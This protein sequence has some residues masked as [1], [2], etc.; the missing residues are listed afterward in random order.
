MFILNFI[1]LLGTKKLLLNF[2]L[3]VTYFYDCYD[4]L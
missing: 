2:V 3:V 4:V 1:F